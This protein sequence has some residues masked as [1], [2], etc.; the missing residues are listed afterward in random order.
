MRNEEKIGGW[1]ES[2]MDRLCKEYIELLSEDTCPSEKF[3]ELDKRIRENKKSGGVCI[4]IKRCNFIASILSLLND[5]VI[6]VEDFDKFSDELKESI[7]F[8][9]NGNV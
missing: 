8:L 9:L 7:N 3:W 5:G 6:S 4:E 1:Q 2:Y